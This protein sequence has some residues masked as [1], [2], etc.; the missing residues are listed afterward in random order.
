VSTYS[1]WAALAALFDECKLLHSRMG[2][3]SSALLTKAIPL[4]I[5]FDHVTSTG[6]GI[7]FGNVQRLA[8]SRCVQSNNMD[9]GSARHVQSVRIAGNRL[10]ATTALP[11]S[12]TAD[13]GMN[14]QWDVSG[15]DSSAASTVAFYYDV[16]NIVSFRNRA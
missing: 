4:W 9:H 13:I 2:I 1:E 11:T 14:G 3:T 5:A 15:Q 8:G 16:E 6:S 10:Y 7:G 12:T